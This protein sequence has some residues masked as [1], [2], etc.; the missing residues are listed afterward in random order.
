MQFVSIFAPSFLLRWII[1]IWLSVQAL[2]VRRA[3]PLRKPAEQESFGMLLIQVLDGNT[4][5]QDLATL[6]LRLLRRNPWSTASLLAALTIIGTTGYALSVLLR[7]LLGRCDNKDNIL[8]I[9]FL[10]LS[11]EHAHCPM[12]TLCSNPTW[13]TMMCALW[14]LVHPDQLRLIIWV[15]R[16]KKKNPK[17]WQEKLRSYSSLPGQAG[18]NVLLLEKE[19]LH[20]HVRTGAM[21]LTPLA[22]KHMKVIMFSLWSC[23]NNALFR[24]WEFYKRYWACGEDIGFVLQ[25]FFFV[26]SARLISYY[27]LQA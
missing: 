26:F 23:A 19:H 8:F 17:T 10:L 6:A 22:Q 7:L 18:K 27:F 15:W 9:F 25:L 12:Q 2:P 4:P 1:S 3:T 21:P 16:E 5:L 13:S 14:V 20:K 11:P 24:K